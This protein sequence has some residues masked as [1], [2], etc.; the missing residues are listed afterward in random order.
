MAVMSTLQQLLGLQPGS[1]ARHAAARHARLL[2]CGIPLLQHRAEETQAQLRTRLGLTAAA[3]EQQLQK[4]PYL[5]LHP[6]KRWR[7]G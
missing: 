1:E 6:S 2:M 3:A 7:G 4:A 5:L